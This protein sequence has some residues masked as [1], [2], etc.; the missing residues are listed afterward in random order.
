MNRREQRKRRT[1]SSFSLFASVGL[2]AP[3]ASIRRTSSVVTGGE[4]NGSWK[5]TIPPL[6]CEAVG[7]LRPRRKRSD[8]VRLSETPRSFA[9]RAA[10]SRMSSSRVGVVLTVKR[11]LVSYMMSINGTGITPPLWRRPNQFHAPLKSSADLSA[12]PSPRGL[13]KHLPSAICH[14][15]STTP[16]H[17]RA[18]GENFSL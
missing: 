17:P 1:E 5:T 14:L 16:D 12:E 11:C 8:T 7:A 3:S 13:R 15:P 9:W 6:S 2:H 18:A 4:S 10:S